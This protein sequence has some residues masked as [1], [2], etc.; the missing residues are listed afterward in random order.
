VPTPVDVAVSLQALHELR[1]ASRAPG[2]YRQLRSVLRPDAL[3]LI[4][5]HLRTDD[6]DRPLFM[7]IDEHIAALSAGGLKQPQLGLDVNG[8]AMFT[9]ANIPEER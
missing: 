4:C 5:D 7:S 8:M 1:N 3:V 9:A 6:D 2:F